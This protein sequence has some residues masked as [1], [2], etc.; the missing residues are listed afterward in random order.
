MLSSDSACL[1]L[2]VAKRLFPSA[3]F[4]AG[5]HSA[6]SLCYQEAES[7]HYSPP[8]LL[9]LQK[10]KKE[11]EGCMGKYTLSSVFNSFW[12]PAGGS[13]HML[14]PQ[15]HIAIFSCRTSCF[16]LCAE[17]PRTAVL[18]HGHLWRGPWQQQIPQD[19]LSKTFLVPVHL[20][21]HPPDSNSL[22]CKQVL[23]NSSN[24]SIFPQEHGYSGRASLLRYC[25]ITVIS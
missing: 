3:L 10:K 18:T 20:A 14:Q 17:T 25:S 23:C 5:C 11:K 13:L 12:D 1:K 22:R 15:M 9:L 24:Q 19:V 7:S 21:L 2:P 8:L 6:A 4:A 16:G